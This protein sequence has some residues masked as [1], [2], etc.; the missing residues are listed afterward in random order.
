MLVIINQTFSPTV[1][2]HSVALC[3]S[4]RRV[5]I[6]ADPANAAGGVCTQMEHKLVS[7]DMSLSLSLSLFLSLY[8]S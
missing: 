4:G 6:P 2:C 1:Q 3:W 7:A 5:H 8:P